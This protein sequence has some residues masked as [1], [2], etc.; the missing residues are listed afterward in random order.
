MSQP[1][2]IPISLDDD[3]VRSIDFIRTH[4]VEAETISPHSFGIYASGVERDGDV[5]TAEW[6]KGDS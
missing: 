2:L 5:Y 6:M 3:V 4:N 1:D